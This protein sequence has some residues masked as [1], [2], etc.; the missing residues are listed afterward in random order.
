MM[1]SAAGQTLSSPNRH[2]ASLG[3]GGAVFHCTPEV[4]AIFQRWHIASCPVDPQRTIIFPIG[5]AIEPHTSFPTPLEYC[6]VPQLGAFSY[7]HSV[8]ERGLSVGRYCSIGSGCRVMAHRHPAEWATT[9]PFAYQPEA[10]FMTAHLALGSRDFVM[11]GY[12]GDLAAM[13]RIGNDVW[14]GQ[15]V[16]LARGITIG[17][18]AVIAAGAVVTK[19]V[20]PYTIVGGSP[21]RMLRARFTDKL[22]EAFLATRWWDYDVR[23]FE[24]SNFRQPERFL[25][26]VAR[27]KAEATLPHYRPP[28]LTYEVMR[29][30]LA[31]AA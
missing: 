8:I 1:Q 18:G 5:V 17:D 27:V 24:C 11:T 25:A 28:A 12:D 22:V 16:L 31:P 30:A 14:I 19:D 9:S 23:I 26:D 4:A 29:A 13:P 21:A 7:S 6:E 2:V 10:Y 20:A 15:D 3:K